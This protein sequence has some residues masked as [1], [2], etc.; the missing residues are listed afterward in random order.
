LT[1]SQAVQILFSQLAPKRGGV[2]LD[3]FLESERGLSD[4]TDHNV[5][6]NMELDAIPSTAG[7]AEA[8][9][10]HGEKSTSNTMEDH[11]ESME[12]E[13]QLPPPSKDGPTDHLDAAA[14]AM[15]TS[16][17]TLASQASA[18]DFASDGAETGYRNYIPKPVGGNSKQRRATEELTRRMERFLARP[19]GTHGHEPTHD[20]DDVPVNEDGAQSND[21]DF[22]KRLYNALHDVYG[23]DM[24]DNVSVVCPYKEGVR[25]WTQMINLKLSEQNIERIND[26]LPVLNNGNHPRI[27][28]NDGAQGV[29]ARVVIIDCANGDGTRATQGFFKKERVNMAISRTLDVATLSGNPCDSKAGT[30]GSKDWPAHKPE[31]NAA[32]SYAGFNNGLI[33]ADKSLVEL[34]HTP[35]ELLPDDEYQDWLAIRRGGV[36]SDAADELVAW[37]ADVDNAAPTVFTAAGADAWGANPDNTAS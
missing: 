7:D 15:A 33:K 19:S 34:K 17:L 32:H 20:H 10:V 6:N 18:S 26:G 36:A 11:G 5:H 3:S 22:Y 13:S 30:L 9:K 25:R 14:K 16:G 8:D 2:S 27:L 35:E 4:V 29:E 12:S 28:S 31:L 24:Y 23:E 1:S 37:G 21:N